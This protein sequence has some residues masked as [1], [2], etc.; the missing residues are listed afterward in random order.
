MRAPADL[1]FAKSTDA[2]L[3]KADML[4]SIGN[5]ALTNLLTPAILFFALGALA[6]WAKSDLTIPDQAVK[7][8]SLYLMVCIG[9]KG[10]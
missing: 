7:A 1:G 9:F 10:G 6:G 5:A 4:E 3:R 2:G 8:L